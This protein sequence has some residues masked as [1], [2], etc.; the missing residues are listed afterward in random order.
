M[1]KIASQM[2]AMWRLFGEMDESVS[3]RR[4][5]F[6]D[7]G[8]LFDVSIGQRTPFAKTLPFAHHC[9][10]ETFNVRF[11]ATLNPPESATL[12]KGFGRC[13]AYESLQGTNVGCCGLA[14]WGFRRDA[15]DGGVF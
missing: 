12:V 6:Q 9:I 14:L 10:F 5:L 1:L 11:R 2:E 13:L 7:D 8:G 15:W 4:A 3:F